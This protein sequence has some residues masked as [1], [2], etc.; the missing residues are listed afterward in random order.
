L[1]RSLFP[2]RTS[3]PVLGSSMTGG[4]RLSPIEPLPAV[5]SGVIDRRSASQVVS[6]DVV[7]RD[8]EM[9][10][11]EPAAP[12]SPGVSRGLIISILA[13][14]VVGSVAFWLLLF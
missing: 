11:D 7:D 2:E 3:T 13:A 12:H 4:A 1:I 5:M 10:F 8:V 6:R 14:C 9:G